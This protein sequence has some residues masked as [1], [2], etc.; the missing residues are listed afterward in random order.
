MGNR[1]NDGRR[2]PVVATELG[3]VWLGFPLWPVLVGSLLVSGA[4]AAIVINEIHFNP[5]IKTE[6]VEFIELFNAGSNTVDLAGWYFS[7]G[8]NFTFPAGAQLGT[9]SY[10]VV[11]ENPPALQSKFGVSALG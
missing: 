8:I 2:F 3:S 1:A 10:V 11:A 6:P 5:D 7:D 9:G 4:R